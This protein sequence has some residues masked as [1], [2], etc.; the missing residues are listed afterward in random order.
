L[1]EFDPETKRTGPVTTKIIAACMDSSIS[2]VDLLILDD[3]TY[4]LTFNSYLCSNQFTVLIM[5]ERRNL[6]PKVAHELKSLCQQQNQLENIE[7]KEEV[8]FMGTEAGRLGQAAI[9][10]TISL[11]ENLKTYLKEILSV[12]SEEYD[13]MMKTMIEEMKEYNSYC[14]LLNFIYSRSFRITWDD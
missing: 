5:L 2:Y 4:S 12:D 3:W 13:E 7:H 9:D 10:D 11:F 8:F 1:M 6:F 14:S